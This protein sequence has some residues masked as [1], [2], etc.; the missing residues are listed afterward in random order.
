MKDTDKQTQRG[1]KPLRVKELCSL[2]GY[3]MPTLYRM[4]EAGE[5]KAVKPRNAWLI[6]YE[7]AKEQFG[8]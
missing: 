7:A 3:S 4:L 6:N 8:F 5:I 2:S 1:Q